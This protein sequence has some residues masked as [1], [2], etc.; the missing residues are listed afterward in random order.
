MSWIHHADIVGLFLLGLDNPRADG[1]L[2]GTAPQP[3]TNMEFT[4]ALGRA[5][6][7]PTILPT[8]RFGLRLLL[9]EVADVV[10]TGQRVLPRVPLALDY[11]YRFPTVDAALSDVLA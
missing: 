7:R 3:V 2:N 6:H 5:L 9:G 11:A 1:P 10:A 4:K 8:P